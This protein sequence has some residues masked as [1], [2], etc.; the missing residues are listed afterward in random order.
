V[1]SIVRVSGN[2]NRS[3]SRRVA[4]SQEPGAHTTTHT[5]TSKYLSTMIELCFFVSLFLTLNP[6]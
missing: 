5:H 6:P 2:F 4:M 1:S 3:R